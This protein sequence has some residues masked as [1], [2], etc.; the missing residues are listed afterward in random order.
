[1]NSDLQDPVHEL[2]VQLR[3]GHSAADG[4]AACLFTLEVQVR[5]LPIQPDAHRLKLACQY[6]WHGILKR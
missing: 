4:N 1:M 5:R 6:L 3:E 2:V